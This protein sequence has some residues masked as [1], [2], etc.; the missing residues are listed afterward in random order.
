MKTLDG[1]ME[2]RYI[3]KISVENKCEV[4]TKQFYNEQGPD[5]QDGHIMKG[6]GFCL[7]CKTCTGF[8]AGRRRDDKSRSGKERA[9][10]RLG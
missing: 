8:V 9:H 4:Y 10:C 2:E 3:W 1:G 7:D 6:A 5:F